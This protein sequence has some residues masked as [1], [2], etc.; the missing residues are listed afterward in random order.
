MKRA[1]KIAVAVLVVAAVIIIAW[2]ITIP[3]P[4]GFAGGHSVSIEEYQGVNPTGVPK[5]LKDATLVRRGEY[6]AHA[7]DC[8]G[9]HTQSGGLPYAGGAVFATPFGK[10]YST[11]ITPD[12]DTGIGNYSDANFLA[13]LRQ[14]IR[15]DGARLYPA[16]PYASYTYMTDADALAIKA[17]LFSLSPV[18]SVPPT[19]ALSFPFNK[20]FMMT[21]WSMFFDSNKRFAAHSDRSDQW[22]RGA[23]LVEGL[24]HCGECHT[25]RNI[26]E[27]LNNRRK[28]AGE[29]V[30][31][32]VAYNITQDRNGGIGAWT[33]VQ[34]EDYLSH[35]HAETRGSAA[36][37]MGIAVD[38]GLAYMTREDI[39]SVVAY[40]RTIPAVDSDLP[41]VNTNGSGTGLSASPEKLDPEGEIVFQKECA[42]CHGK[43]GVSP[44]TS[45][46]NLSGSRSVNDPSG[47]NVVEI[48]LTGF[49]KELPDD[50]SSMPSFA[51]LLSDQDIASVTNYVTGR[52][53]SKAAE[54]TPA[55]VAERRP[56][57]LDGL[58]LDVA[59]VDVPLNVSTQSIPDQPI[60]FSHSQHL[61]FGLECRS[62]HIEPAP[63]VDMTLPAT[64]T[65]M[66][67]HAGVATARP[68][69]KRLADYA[70]A[71]KDVP[72]VRMY[73]VI[74]GVNWSHATHLQA[75]VNC[76]ACHGDVSKLSVMKEVTSVTSMA[77]CIS[78]HQAHKVAN[79]SACATCHAWPP[80]KGLDV[81]P[82]Q[83]PPPL[84]VATV[85]AVVGTK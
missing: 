4:L 64:S 42:G 30:D 31:G 32:W 37:P 7:A 80:A 79:G 49:H 48:V 15:P 56:K 63:G 1:P 29:L 18:H 55:S 36:G 9:C 39:A 72:W 20:R 12:K 82:E 74:P 85:N 68:E 26:M 73:D 14:G 24:G 75:G 83:E 59:K 84:D 50:K 61:S 33:D 62:C 34:L 51:S 65:C 23:Y 3:G 8:A 38:L 70:G 16:M 45:F 17:Y 66:G 78:C 43:D 11:N 60:P 25:P 53:G 77:N 69:I 58:V 2:F 28:F 10:M 54:A 41:P 5:E 71:H 81:W 57:G 35:G 52:F 6:L 21:F 13:A 22:N 40:L 47:K 44:F 76:V 67:C 27:G 19:N 46:A